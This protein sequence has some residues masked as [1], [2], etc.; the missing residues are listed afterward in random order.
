MICVKQVKVSPSRISIKTGEAYYGATAQISPLNATNPTVKWSISNPNIAYI[1]P[2]NGTIYGKNE[3]TAT[4]YAT[5]QDESG[6]RDCCTIVVSKRILVS[7][8]TLDSTNLHLETNRSITVPSATIFPENADNKTVRWCSENPNVATIENGKIYTHSEGRATITVSATDGSGVTA[9]CKVAVYKNIYISSV[10]VSP[11]SKAMNVGESAYLHATICPTNAT[12]KQIM[13]LSSDEDVAIVNPS[14]GL[15]T[16]T[17]VGT[18]TIYA[19]SLDN[20]GK[21]DS[22]TVTVDQNVRIRSITFDKTE[23]RLQPGDRYTLSTTICP[24]NATDK[25]LLWYSNNPEVAS[26]N[27]GVIRAKSKGFAEIS[28]SPTAGSTVSARCKV[29]VSDYIPVSSV[30]VS[31]SC[32]TMTV[33]DS[34]YL[35]ATVCPGNATNK[36]IEWKSGN[37]D[38]VSVAPDTG[39]LI[40]QG[41]GTTTVF[42]MTLEGAGVIGRCTVTVKDVVP[43][44]S[45]RVCPTEK[46]M[47]VGE[48][49]C[50]T[51]IVYP[52]NATNKAVR[53]Y[54]D[55]PNVATVDHLSGQIHAKLAGTTNITAVTADGGF[56]TSSTVVVT[57]VLTGADIYIDDQ[58]IINTII[59]AKNLSDVAYDMYLSGSISC[60]QLEK[61]Q[62]EAKY[63]ADLAR[64][65]FVLSLIHI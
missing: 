44:S 20:S 3:G 28:A 59:N 42:A 11:S 41:P 21:R 17:G 25:S 35:H 64:A 53:W 47:R 57:Q 48:S 24:S 12:N 30:T 63:V 45:V 34:I 43:V 27:N 26:V 6:K 60:E 55:N 51:A 56:T 54:S 5:A 16:A 33:G 31:P 37:E 13:W 58:N 36:F 38:I 50:L 23:L 39:L 49:D 22:C 15:V 2:N 4:I 65:D 9:H 62:K 1:N 14:S 7:S 29:F 19:E 52:G 46:S 32:K 8:I 61:M 10:T 18:A 40:A